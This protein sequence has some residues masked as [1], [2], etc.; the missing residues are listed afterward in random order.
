[1]SQRSIDAAEEPD[2]PVAVQVW[3]KT[4]GGKNRK[5]LGEVR[6]SS[7]GLVFD[8]VLPINFAPGQREEMTEHFR[9]LGSGRL[10]IPVMQSRSR[11][12]IEDPGDTPRDEPKV[13]CKGTEITLTR[14]ELVEAARRQ[15][16]VTKPVKVTVH[17]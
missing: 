17:H 1:M 2:R 5:P 10:A 14:T 7:V 11:I 6:R 15:T 13:A 12:L 8:A 16:D 9:R 4:C 3:C